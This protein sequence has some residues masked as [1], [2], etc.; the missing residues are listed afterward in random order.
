MGKCHYAI[1]K[2]WNQNEVCQG[3]TKYSKAMKSAGAD[4][5][6]WDDAT[7]AE[8]LAKPRTMIKGTK[9]SFAGFKK[10]S[11]ITAILEYL[12]SAGG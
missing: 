4:G 3:F 12:R 1:E 9:M 8:F 10:E 6:V 11:E 2:P 7:L 5:L